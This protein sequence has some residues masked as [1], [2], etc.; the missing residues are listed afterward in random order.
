VINPSKDI[1]DERSPTD[2]SGNDL[3]V[4]QALRL[5]GRATSDEL[6]NATGL[7]DISVK[8]SVAALLAA[9]EVREMRG[10]YTLLPPA[11]DRLKALLAQE[12]A[13][14][15]TRAV[16]ELYEQFTCVND[17]FKALAADWQTRDGEPNDHREAVY[18]ESVLERLP[19]IH[20]RVRPIAD[21]LGGLVPRMAPYCDRLAA[22]LARVQSGESE[23][24]LKP[25][26]DSYH[27]VW[28]ELHEELIALAGLTRLDEAAAGRAH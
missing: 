18:D 22:A 6:A 12:R 28:F 5:K 14:V 23:W 24:L 4:L 15:D 21:R 27:T 19:R 2:M 13:A 10:G 9:G 20:A 3:P 16:A 26:I 7:P 11:R 25:L 1:H 17:D 8:H